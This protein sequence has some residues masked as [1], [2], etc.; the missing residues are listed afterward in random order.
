[1]LIE[2]GARGFDELVRELIWNVRPPE[3]RT[4][5]GIVRPSS[6]EEVAAAIRLATERGLRVSLRGS[7]HNYQGA[8]LRDDGLLI[9][10]GALHRIEIDAAARR[11]WV[12]AGVKGGRLIGELAERGLAFPIG[13]CS[14]VALSGY[15]LAGGIGWNYGE[16]G[17]ACANVTAIEMVTATGALIIASADEHPDLFWAARGA[18]CAFFAA[19]TAYELVLHDLP[20]ACFVLEASFDAGAADAIAQWLNEAGAKAHPSVELICLVGPDAE[21]GGPGITVRA[22]ASA[23]SLEGARSKLGPLLTLPAGVPLLRPAEQHE[24]RFSELTRFSA[25]PSGK[26]VG[27]DQ[28]WSEQAIGDLLLSVAH[29]ATGPQASSAISL[30]ALGGRATT[31]GM[32]GEVN[33]ALSLGGTTSAGVYALWDGPENDRL[34]LDW[35]AAADAALAPFRSGR[36]VGEADLFIEPDRIG[37]CFSTTALA[38]LKELRERYDPARRFFSCL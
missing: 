30:T 3:E 27:A 36:Y 15:V 34:H 33:G 10:I 31:P 8:A 23:G 13:H 1:M 14:D 11:A 38:R 25:M 28:I 35:V 20:A 29:L 32:P 24:L 19:V 12:G 21:T 22:V 26:R 18:G 16:W 6:P 37:Q 4:P 9:D 2:K 5:D 7:G 17:P